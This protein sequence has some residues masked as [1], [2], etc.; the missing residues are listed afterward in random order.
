MDKTLVKTSK[1]LSLILRHKPDEI[2]LTLDENGW[3]DVEE[4]IR[5]ANLKGIKLTREILEAVVSGN[6]KKRFVL[7]E[8]KR[9]IR[10]NQG[11]SINVELGIASSVPPQ[12]LY[13]GTATRFIESIKA[14]GINSGSRQHVHLSQDIATAIT[15]GA[16]HGKPEVL[17]ILAAEM[18]QTGH[19]FYLSENGVWLTDQVPVEF[20]R[21]PSN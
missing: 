18:A 11:H 2:G 12:F 16:R 9:R 6:D 8:D 20:I 1:F 7:S 5:L 3:A 4:L 13:H 14:Q 10:A 15:V 19:L 17:T 21:F